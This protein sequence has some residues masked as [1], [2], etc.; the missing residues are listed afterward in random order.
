MVGTRIYPRYSNAKC[1]SL[2]RGEKTK[3]ETV[4][5]F[6]G[7]RTRK[8]GN[9]SHS[10]SKYANSTPGCGVLTAAPWSGFTF[11]NIVLDGALTGFPLRYNLA[12]TVQLSR[13][14]IGPSAFGELMD[15]TEPSKV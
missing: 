13:I 4:P 12:V 7:V 15:G 10:P 3:F 6:A 11:E 5:F 2:K 14:R 1:S 8:S 9:R